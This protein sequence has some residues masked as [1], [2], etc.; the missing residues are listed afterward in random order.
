MKHIIRFPTYMNSFFKE[1]EKHHVKQ[2]EYN[3]LLKVLKH[4][5]SLQN[6]TIMER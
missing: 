4:I 3:Y 6:K 5:L 1:S 2:K